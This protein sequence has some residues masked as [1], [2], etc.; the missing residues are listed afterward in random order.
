MLENMVVPGVALSEAELR[1]RKTPLI[2]ADNQ[3]LVVR[4]RLAA[5]HFS[6]PVLAFV[7]RALVD[8]ARIPHTDTQ[9]PASSESM[10]S[11]APLD[12]QIGS[13]DPCYSRDSAVR[14]PG[15]TTHVF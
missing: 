3:T 7:M 6:R 5:Q 14:E 9:G 1:V 15:Q 4:P 13:L 10:P 2:T 12:L 8:S 11:T